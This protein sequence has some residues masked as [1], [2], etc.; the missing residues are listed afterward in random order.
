MDNTD[1]TNT[2]PEEQQQQQEQEQRLEQHLEQPQQEPQRHSVYELDS[3]SIATTTTLSPPAPT[4]TESQATP[5]VANNTMPP[6]T[7]Q[8]TALRNKGPTACQPRPSP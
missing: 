4:Q 1:N 8:P 6:P 2:V 7:N 5:Q 3:Q